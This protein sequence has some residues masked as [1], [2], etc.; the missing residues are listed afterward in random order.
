MKTITIKSAKKECGEC[1]ACCEGWLNGEV[2]GKRFSAGTPCHF[3]STT[4][5]SIY[6]DRPQDPCKSYNCEWLTNEEFPLWMQ[7]NV[8]NVIVSKKKI[9][10]IEYYSAITTGKEMSAAALNWLFT[11]AVPKQ[12]NLVYKIQGGVYKVGSPEFSQADIGA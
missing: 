10:G 11:W 2:Y 3:M 5:C 4:G 6:K 7:P 8:S 12:F 9:N 1:K